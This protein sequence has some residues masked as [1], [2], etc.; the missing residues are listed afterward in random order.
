MKLADHGAHLGGEP[1]AGGALERGPHLVHP[2]ARQLRHHEV[3]PAVEIIGC[4]QRRRGDRQP[5]AEE[6]ERVA[7]VVAVAAGCGGTA[8]GRA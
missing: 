2:A 7:L 8:A 4:P 1:Q 3:R 6:G 5:S